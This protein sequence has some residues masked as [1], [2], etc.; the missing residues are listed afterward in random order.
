MF[1]LF[2]KRSLSNLNSFASWNELKLKKV[3]GLVYY[4]MAK[5]SKMIS[6]LCYLISNIRAKIFKVNARLFI[7]NNTGHC[8]SISAVW[9]ASLVALLC[10]RLA[11][12]PQTGRPEY[13]R[14]LPADQAA[15]RLHHNQASVGVKNATVCSSWAVFE[16]RQPS[17]CQLFDFQQC[18]VYLW[19]LHCFKMS[20]K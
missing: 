16:G 17:V 6:A 5:F 8:W 18:K 15:D 11:G 1:H 4:F 19:C 13:L 14:V 3:T 7:Y 20:S 12:L 9:K 10:A 2:Y